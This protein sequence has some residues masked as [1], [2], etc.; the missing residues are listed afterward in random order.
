LF[1]RVLFAVEDSRWNRSCVDPINYYRRLYK[2]QLD[3][4]SFC[5]RVNSNSMR[6]VDDERRQNIDWYSRL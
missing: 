5:Q 1:L 2:R 6:V 4:F 3:R